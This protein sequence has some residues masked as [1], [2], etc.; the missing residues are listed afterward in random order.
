MCLCCSRWRR[1]LGLNC[2]E[3]TQ[4]EAKI[5][6]R[7]ERKIN[8]CRL[9]KENEERRLAIKIERERGN[10]IKRREAL[11]ELIKIGKNY[12]IVD[13]EYRSLLRIL[14][15]KLFNILKSRNL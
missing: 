15:I 4:R 7:L 11:A 2:H 1:C 5:K 13:Y 9:E 10:E 6:H 14:W 3:K 8:K 12:H